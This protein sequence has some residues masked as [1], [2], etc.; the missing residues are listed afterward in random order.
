MKAPDKIF[1]GVVEGGF[2]CVNTVS[3]PSTPD[4]YLRKDALLEWAKEK[5]EK[6]ITRLTKLAYKTVI[7]KI[8]SL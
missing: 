6:A 3:T 4:A 2:Q 1:Y 7:D 8:N 5:E